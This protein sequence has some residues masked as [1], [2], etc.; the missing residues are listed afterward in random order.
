MVQKRFAPGDQ[1][2][3]KFKTSGPNNGS[4]IDMG[5]LINKK[6]NISLTISGKARGIKIPFNFKQSWDFPLIELKQV[7]DGTGFSIVENRIAEIPSFFPSGSRAEL[8]IKAKINGL[9]KG[10]C[11]QSIKIL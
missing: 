4:L 3:L 6:V 7:R 10:S 8:T 2:L 5:R 1:V 11:K 9:G